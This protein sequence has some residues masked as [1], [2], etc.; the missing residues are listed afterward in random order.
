MSDREDAIA[1]LQRLRAAGHIAYFAGGCVRDLLLGLAPKDYDVATDAPPPV[2]R[3]LFPNTQAVGAAFGVI[4][5]RQ[6]KSVIEVATFRSDGR[7]SDG[8]HP[9]AVRFTTAQEDAQRRDFTINGLFLD[10]LKN[11]VI[12][13]VGGREDLANHR[14]RAIGDAE[15]RFEEDHLRMLR[16]VRFA[17]RFDLQIEPAT[18]TAIQAAAARLKGISPERIAEEL[19]LM[20][21]PISRRRAWPL[22]W[23]L[24]LGTVI[25]R[26]FANASGKSLFLAVAPQS[27]IDFGLALAAAVLDVRSSPPGDI[28]PLFEKA[29]IRQSVAAMRKTLKISNEE[30]D[31]MAGTMAG[32]AP[33]LADTPPRLAAKKRFLAEPTAGLSRLL[34]AA[35]AACGWH[36]QRAMELEKAFSELE[37]TQFAP[38]PLITGDDLTAAGLQP[39][40]AFKQ[41]LDSVYDAQLEGAVCT[42]Q[43][44]LDLAIS[45]TKTGG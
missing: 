23:E 29:E 27:P 31:A 4:L 5:V 41:I 15:V 3:K 33:L 11:E 24:G 32:I 21:T 37:K 38:E 1:V 10:P 44:A 39:G 43:Q 20:L 12:D 13:F 17:A 19:R 25:F 34:L 45:P 18:A 40:P 42:R 26:A 30:S 36:S 9:D 22:L 7:Y 2:V 16:A 28:R 6:G 14:L 35:L 8:R